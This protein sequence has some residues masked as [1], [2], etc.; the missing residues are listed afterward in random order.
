MERRAAHDARPVPHPCPL[1]APADKMARSQRPLSKQ[2]ESMRGP[3]ILAAGAVFVLSLSCEAPNCT[4]I[5]TIYTTSVNA[6]ADAGPRAGLPVARF[7][8]SQNFL[9]HEPLGCVGAPSQDVGAVDLTVT[10]TATVTQRVD[11]AIQ[12][13]NSVNNPVWSFEDTLVAIA[14]GQ[15]VTVGRVAVTPT[16]V[17]LGARVVFKEVLPEP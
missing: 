6:V 10:S 1:D 2:G 16:R 8:L 17:D 13:L 4:R 7:D 14:P 3:F 9:T 11:Y 12:G 5:S 15:T